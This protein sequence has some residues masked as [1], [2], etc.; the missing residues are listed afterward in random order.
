MKLASIGFAIVGFILLFIGGEGIEPKTE[1]FHRYQG[2]M[3]TG[4][5]VLGFSLLTAIVGIWMDLK[6]SRTDDAKQWLWHWILVVV[7]CMTFYMFVSLQKEYRELIEQKSAGTT[8]VV[9]EG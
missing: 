8:E 2:L 4:Y 9:E 1:D 3:L 5:W 7:A 6:K